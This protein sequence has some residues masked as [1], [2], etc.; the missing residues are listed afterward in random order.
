MLITGKNKKKTTACP[1]NGYFQKNLAYLAYL[2]DSISSR[3]R[4]IVCQLATKSSVY[5]SAD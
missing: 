3:Q 2:A 5:L 1:K 4:F